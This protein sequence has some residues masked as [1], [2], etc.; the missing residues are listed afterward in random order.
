MSTAHCSHAIRFAT[1]TA[2]LLSAGDAGT[3]PRKKYAAATL[4]YNAVAPTT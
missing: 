4:V 2:W 3:L 1:A